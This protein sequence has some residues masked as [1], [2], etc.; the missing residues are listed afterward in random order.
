MFQ[1]DVGWMM[2]WNQDTMEGWNGRENP[3]RNHSEIPCSSLFMCRKTDPRIL[4]YL[5]IPILPRHI[6]IA[7]D[8][9]LEVHPSSIASSQEP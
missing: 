8:G 5:F 1:R 2:L 3:H 6:F 4:Q 9:I 7:P